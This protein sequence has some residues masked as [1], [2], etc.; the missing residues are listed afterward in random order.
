MD[1]S[2]L[3]QRLTIVVAARAHPQRDATAIGT[4]ASVRTPPGPGNGM[5]IISTCGEGTFVTFSAKVVF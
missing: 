3:S 4:S 5:Q 2:R 1:E